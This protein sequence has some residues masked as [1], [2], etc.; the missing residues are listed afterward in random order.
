MGIG[1][2]LGSSLTNFVRWVLK[3]KKPKNRPECTF[4]AVL[5][6]PKI[7]VR[8]GAERCRTMIFGECVQ[9]EHLVTV[10]LILFFFNLNV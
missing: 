9:K 4:N 6:A 2:I 5:I 8:H 3:I 1:K 10:S 7:I